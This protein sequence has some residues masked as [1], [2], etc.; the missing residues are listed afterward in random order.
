MLRRRPALSQPIF[1]RPTR[2]SLA[3]IRA[4]LATNRQV[5]AEA[6][7]Y[8]PG[9]TRKRFTFQAPDFQYCQDTCDLSPP[10]QVVNYDANGNCTLLSDVTGYTYSPG[11]VTAEQVPN[12]PP[13]EPEV[14]TTTTT[15][16]SLAPAPTGSFILAV[17]ARCPANNGSYVLDNCGVGYILGCYL[18][19]QPGSNDFVSTPTFNDC[20]QA[21]SSGENGPCSA[22]SWVEGN[23][24]CY[25]KRGGGVSFF[26]NGGSQIGAI[27]LAYY[28]NGSPDPTST[29]RV[30]T[31]PSTTSSSS[32]ATS[33]SSSASSSVASSVA[34]VS[35]SASSTVSSSSAELSPSSTGTWSTTS[36]GVSSSTTT[37]SP[38]STTS[39]AVSTSTAPFSCPDVSGS[40]V[41]DA[42]GVIYDV[43]CDTTIP[44]AQIDTRVAPGGFN[45]CFQICDANTLCTGFTFLNDY[46]YIKGDVL[47]FDQ[48]QTGVFAAIRRGGTYNPNGPSTSSSVV[49]TSSSAAIVIV[50]TTS[51]P[52]QT[53]SSSSWSSTW[54]SSVPATSSSG[55]ASQ[56]STTAGS[57]SSTG[58]SV[59]SSTASTTWSASESSTWSSTPGLSSSESSTWSSTWSSVPG[60]S[61]SESSSSWSSS[62]SQSQAQV[63][64]LTL[65]SA[66]GS[67]VSPSSAASSMSSGTVSITISPY[68]SPTSS[69]MEAGSSSAGVY[70]GSS[71]ASSSAG[72][73]SSVAD[74]S[75]SAAGASSTWSASSVPGASSSAGVSAGSSIP[76]ASSTPGGSVVPSGS[77]SGSAS[78][79]PATSV[80]SSLDVPISPA[81]SGSQS[82]GASSSP[83]GQTA[84][85]TMPT[86]YFNTSSSA[87]PSQSVPV[88]QSPGQSQSAGSQTPGGNPTPGS[89][90]GGITTGPTPTGGSATSGSTAP[91]PSVSVC[92]YYDG[93]NYTSPSGQ[94]Y[95]VQCDSVYTGTRLTNIAARQA[96][97]APSQASC[98]A[99]CQANDAC[100]A[101][102]V[103][104]TEC[105]YLSSIDGMDTANGSIALLKVDAPPAPN[106]G[107]VTVTVCKATRTTTI[108]TT[109]TVTTCAADRSCPASARPTGYGKRDL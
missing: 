28:D 31:V 89:S 33:S 72:A 69:S 23:G 73:S 46:C 80:S 24:F 59:W 5:P 41:V 98:M 82:A 74:V 54:S 50:S 40:T 79:G 90:Q 38:S 20:F 19:T 65:S 53:S 9:R 18:D 76:G 57:V 97:Y 92:P 94:T 17:D 10:C 101:I 26:Q 12:P 43:R 58:S 22:F 64:S 7:N 96:S 83:T 37:S 11:T 68:P 67:T 108:L 104:P 81:Q 8:P 77:A 39:L 85:P 52:G 25:L 100:V 88:S 2:P 75:S 91:T 93:Q 45:D 3:L 103:T 78:V 14:V 99:V 35:A 107:V 36:E 55:S 84:M 60:A 4:R 66:L 62:A 27:Q 32:L 15:T 95:E 16:S 105:Q 56:S 13:P 102:N 71:A 51:T 21:C 106:G 1:A 44:G 42:Y 109:A 29:S 34:S 86:G 49:S 47:A 61:S 70:S 87:R 30:C 6:V 63:S 48:P